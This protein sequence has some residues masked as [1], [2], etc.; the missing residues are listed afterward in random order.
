MRVVPSAVRWGSQQLSLY[1]ANP[2]HITNGRTLCEV[3]MGVFHKHCLAV[4]V[5]NKAHD[6]KELPDLLCCGMVWSG[7]VLF[8]GAP[9]LERAIMMLRSFGCRAC[10]VWYGTISRTFDSFGRT[11]GYC[12]T[13]FLEAKEKRWRPLTG[14]LLATD[15]APYDIHL[16]NQ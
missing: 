9:G 10:M 5:S 13:F 3:P 4:K 8:N 7:L 12:H 11:W 16:Q 2:T 15:L 1:F 6:Q 14:Y